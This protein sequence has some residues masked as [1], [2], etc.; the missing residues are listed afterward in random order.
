MCCEKSWSAPWTQFFALNIPEKLSHWRHRSDLKDSKS[1]VQW[2]WVYRFYMTSSHFGHGCS[3]NVARGR[4]LPHVAGSSPPRG[5]HAV[6]P[7]HVPAGLHR[8]AVCRVPPL[9]LWRCLHRSPRAARHPVGQVLRGVGEPP[10]HHGA[11]TGSPWLL[12]S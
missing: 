10:R 2:Q 4:L 7:G 9:P 6:V 3:F 8:H 5:A 1:N 12:L 11:N